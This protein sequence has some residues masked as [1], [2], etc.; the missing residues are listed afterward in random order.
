MP[1]PPAVP[2]WPRYQLTAD[3]DGSV[4][5]TGPATPVRAY[6]GRAAAI[7]AVAELAAILTPP[8]EVAADA[9]D[10]DGTCW[11]LYISPDGTAR[12]AGPA[13]RRK[14]RRW[15]AKKTP[16]A[17]APVA[18]SPQPTPAPE[19]AA[20][21]AP[22]PQF[23]PP[24]P[25]PAAPAEDA[26]TTRVRA[27]RP[28]PAPVLEQHERPAD[29]TSA[30]PAVPQ[31]VPGARSGPTVP[32]V[33]HIRAM[34]EDGQTDQA[35]QM[36][37]ALD[38]AASRAHGP[39]H[40]AALEAREI[41]AHLTAEAGDIPAAVHLYRDAAERWALQ[42]A[43]EAA[44]AAAGRAHALWLR[45]LPQLSPADALAVGETIVRMRTAVPGR[46][47]RPYRQARQRLTELQ[48]AAHTPGH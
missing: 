20:P 46:D 10:T 5:V 27:R 2:P 34:A 44:D 29:D 45:H 16:A 33:L 3:P 39:S 36:A 48:A 17:P 23:R 22:L 13:R 21:A 11:P 28:R 24:R 31:A 35:R 38:D 42:N 32:S 1:T 25:A 15:S 9:I 8:R 30:A 19:A 4:T 47:G 14:R 12:E 41:H 18:A 7:E 6:P 43:P 40:R 26:P 37:A